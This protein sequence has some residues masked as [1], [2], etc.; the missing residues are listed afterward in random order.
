LFPNASILVHFD[1]FLSGMCIN[2]VKWVNRKQCGRWAG[3]IWWK[4]GFF[5]N[6]FLH[7]W[8]TEQCLPFLL[9]FYLIWS[10]FPNLLTWVIGFSWFDPKNESVV[11]GKCIGQ[12]Q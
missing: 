6:Q 3:D 5:A 7:M 8:L 1:L 4:D 12:G 2:L 11:S 10:L 9:P